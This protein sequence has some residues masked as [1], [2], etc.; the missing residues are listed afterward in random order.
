MPQRWQCW[1]HTG[2]LSHGL[3]P[4]EGSPQLEHGRLGQ[5]RQTWPR[6]PQ[7]T[8]VGLFWWNAEK[9]LRTRVGNRLAGGGDEV[10]RAAASPPP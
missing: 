8:H 7:R 9:R 1:F 4:C 3:S 2:G 6:I 5:S 10:K